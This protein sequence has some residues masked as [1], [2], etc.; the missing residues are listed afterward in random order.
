MKKRE[1]KPEKIYKQDKEFISDYYDEH[2]YGP[3]HLNKPNYEDIITNNMI[4]LHL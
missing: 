2:Y 3:A 1:L 4:K